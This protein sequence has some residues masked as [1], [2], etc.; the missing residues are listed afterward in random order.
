MLLVSSD[1]SPQE[2]VGWRRIGGPLVRKYIALFL[3]VVLVVLF[4]NSLIEIGFFYRD[5]KSSLVRAQREQAEAAAAKIGQFIREI[6]SQLGWTTQLPWS[7]STIDQRRFDASRL[8]RQVQAIMEITQLDAAGKEQLRVSRIGM[9]VLASQTDFS[10]EP[11]FTEAIAKNVYYGPIYFRRE[12]EPYMTLALAGARRDAGVSLAEVNLKLIWDVVAAIKVG[13]RGQAFVI[14]AQGRL[15]AHPDINLV[16]RYTD[17]TRLAQVQAARAAGSGA[18]SEPMQVG[19]DIVGR[20]VLTAYASIA[21]LGWL[22]FVELPTDEAYAPLHAAMQR[23]GALL[24]AG[25]TLVFLAGLFFARRITVPIQALRAGAARLGSGDLSQRI[26]IK[27]GDEF[28]ALADQFNSMAAQLQESYANLER[29]VD[30]R[31]HQLELANL[32][33]SRFL[34]TASHDLRQPLHA[35]TLFVAQL[36]DQMEAAE[37]G[38]LVDRID[39]AVAAM[40]ELFNALLDVSKLDAGALAPNIAEFPLAHLLTRI[41]TTFAAAARE[42]GLS[43]RLISTGAWVRSDIIMLE[44]ILLNLVSNAIR[45]TSHG[46]VIVGCRQRGTMLRIEIYDTG[47]GIPEDQHHNI[48]EEFYQLANPERDRR[49]GIG[50]GLAIVDRL[51]RLLDHRVELTST[52]GKGSRFTIIVAMAAAHSVSEVA[53]SPTTTSE[54]VQGK[55][56]VVIDDAPLVLEGMGGLVRNWGFHVVAAKSYDQALAHLAEQNEQPSLIVSDYH[57]PDGRFGIEVIEQMRDVFG[58]PIP[59][60]LVSGDTG[61]E[62]LHRARAKGD[63]LLHKPVNPMRLRAVLNRLMAA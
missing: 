32:A 37:R 53:T 8:L 10:Q 57:L 46:G 19:K 35:L 40:N 29:K 2:H 23:S 50:L 26:S 1:G 9:D 39:A 38:R 13:E 21:Q 25:L 49:G 42:K 33:K 48:F 62:L 54:V 45:Y 63:F 56:V 60:F 34:A 18:A 11:A 5:H 22:V 31:T 58:T 17:M 14:D 12:S 28:E 30:E 3:A 55:T 16:L 15:I 20:E 27:T 24:L 52:I 6:E 44:R 7:A 59:A 36:R 41:E 43:L 51:C 4:A 47:P 61:P